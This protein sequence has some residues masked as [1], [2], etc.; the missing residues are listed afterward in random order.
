MTTMQ[1]TVKLV[2]NKSFEN[3]EKVKY[4]SFEATIT[5]K[6]TSPKKPKPYSIWGVLATVQFILLLVQ[7]NKITSVLYGRDT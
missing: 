4:V 1:N 5:V 7:I 6:I 2:A 3:V